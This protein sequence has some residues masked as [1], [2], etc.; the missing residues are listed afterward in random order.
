M[1]RMEYRCDPCKFTTKNKTNY[2]RH[3]DLQKHFKNVN[4]DTNILLTHSIILP[5]HNMFEKNTHILESNKHIDI[6]NEINLQKINSTQ[7]YKCDYCYNSFSRL[8]SLTRH[9]KVCSENKNKTNEYEK[10]LCQKDMEVQIFQ[11]D[12]QV[13][14][15][16]KDMHVQ[17]F[18]KDLQVQLSQKDME[19][20]LFQKDLEHE[21]ELHKKDLVQAEIYKKEAE[22][23]KEIINMAGGMVQKTV[24][25]LTYI[26]NTYDKAPVIKQITFEDVQKSTKIDDE[27]MISKIFY[28]YNRN[29]LGQYIGDIIVEIY[30]KKDPSEQS[31]WNT[32]TSRLTYLLKK[33]LHDDNSKWMVDK[34][35]VDTIDHLIKPI[36]DRVRE[37]AIDYQE[38][39]CF[40]ENI[41][42]SRVILIN[43]IFSRLMI[44]IDN[45]KIHNDIL[46]YIAPH[47]YLN[48]NRTIEDE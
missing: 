18:Q 47:F 14:L 8:S 34:K 41:D 29:K 25:A 36:I 44:D 1:T 7:E 23:Y 3:C 4:I 39:N 42:A 16:Q 35:G 37:I 26:V 28:H 2:N 24:S 48:V 40:G 27:K 46:K 9:T 33:I 32:D 38:T 19:V 5:S 31:I 17:I 20:K 6:I 22:Y 11:K 43:D 10:K 13:Q 45:R 12:L 30:K 21:R 15:S